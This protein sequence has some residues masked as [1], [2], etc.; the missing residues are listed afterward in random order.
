M[1]LWRETPP[2]PG[3][4]EGNVKFERS[5]GKAVASLKR[6]KKGSKNKAEE[7]ILTKKYS[8]PATGSSR[9]P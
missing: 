6:M 3:E 9:G 7:I 5:R 8:S 4:K 1:N 2:G